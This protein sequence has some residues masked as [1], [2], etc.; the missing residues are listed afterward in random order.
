MTTTPKVLEGVSL[1]WALKYETINHAKITSNIVYMTLSH[2]KNTRPF[3]P[4]LSSHFN[5][6]CLIS[7]LEKHISLCIILG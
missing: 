6:L 3:I 7:I 5:E 4:K 1:P 2:I